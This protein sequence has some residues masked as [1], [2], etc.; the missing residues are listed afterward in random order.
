MYWILLA[1]LWYLELTTISKG[2]NC[3][4]DPV[5]FLILREEGLKCI[6][7][8]GSFAEIKLG[9]LVVLWNVTHWSGKKGPAGV[10]ENVAKYLA[11]GTG[12]VHRDV[13]PLWSVGELDSKMALKLWVTCLC[14]CIHVC[15]F[16]HLGMGVMAHGTIWFLKMSLPP[17][18]WV[19]LWKADQ[20]NLFWL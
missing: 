10:W 15:A 16:A 1:M 3:I 12:Q 4:S 6:S 14:A 18:S 11:E 20:N 5:F 19:T 2:E 8:T 7:E 17:H 13:V 9:W